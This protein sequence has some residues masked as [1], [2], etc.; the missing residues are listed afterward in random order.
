MTNTHLLQHFNLGGLLAIGAGLQIVAQALRTWKPPFPL[1][2]VTFWMVY[3]GQAYQD[4]GCNTY[5]AGV[6]RGAHRW[7][8]FI[9]AMYTAGCLVG[10]FVATPI[11]AANQPSRWNL[12]YCAPLGICVANFVLTC[13]AFRDTINICSLIRM[14]KGAS[15][16]GAA[17]QTGGEATPDDTGVADAPFV[18]IKRTL[19]SKAFWAIGAFYFFY[20]GAVIT[21]SSWVVEFLVQVRDGNIAQMGYVP[22]GFNGGAFLGRVLLAEPTHRFGEKRMI[23]LFVLL[24]IA[25][26]LV[27]WL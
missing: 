20:L 24:C 1:Y 15:S 10:P 4:A 16:E 5:T 8:A 23:L 25:F 6:G 3:L 26:Q 13:Y 18:L 9:H 7:L 12:F 27:F 11:A 19:S 14:K 17:A 2:A 21:A 22:A